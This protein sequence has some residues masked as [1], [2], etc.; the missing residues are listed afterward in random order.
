LAEAAIPRPAAKKRKSSGEPVN[1]IMNGTTPKRPKKSQNS[2]TADRDVVLDDVGGI[3]VNSTADVAPEDIKTSPAQSVNVSLEELAASAT[4]AHARA[5]AS[6]AQNMEEEV[7]LAATSPLSE[8]KFE[9]QETGGH[10]EV[11]NGQGQGASSLVSPPESTH[12]DAEQTP[13]AGA[14]GKATTPPVASRAVPP[15][16]QPPKTTPRFTPD[17]NTQGQ[18]STDGD[19][20][21][22][23]A[24]VEATS[25]MKRRTSRPGSDQTADE[26]SLKL[27]RQ[28]AAQ[29]MGLRRRAKVV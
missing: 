21:S 9:V 11:A 13:P 23:T 16:V 3:P 24:S 2:P 17:S 22:P 5:Q 4:I 6:A 26:E 12:T 10:E 18:A 29:D 19:A 28:L 8:A 1:G 7:N 20:T 27:I 14:P 25:T 15:T